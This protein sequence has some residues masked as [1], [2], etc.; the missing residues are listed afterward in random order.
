MVRR[1]KKKPSTLSLFDGASLAVIED[2]DLVRE[3]ESAY[4]EY[5]MSVIVSRALP[6]IRDG[7]KPVQRRILWGMRTSG[8]RADGPHRKC[9]K[10]VGEVMGSFHPHGDQAIYD[11][12]VRMAQNFSYYVPLVDG[13]GN[14][15][16]PGFPPA[17]MRY[18]ECRMSPTAARM[19]AGIDEDTVDFVPN[20]DGATTEPSVLPA[21]FPNLLVNG[22]E[23]IAVG[24]TTKIPT[25]NP[26]EVINGALLVLDRPDATPRQ[27]ARKIKGPDFASG[28]DILDTSG[29]IAAAYSTG[30]GRF[31]TRASVEV[32]D[33]KRGAT[34]LLFRNLPP[35][36]AVPRIADTIVDQIKKNRLASVSNVIDASDKTGVELQVVIKKGHS[37][38]AAIADLFKYTPLEQVFAVTMRALVDGVPV[39]CSLAT[40]LRAFCDHR[41]DVVL[42]R[43]IHRREKAKARRHI[44]RALIK[45]LDRIDEVIAAIKASTDVKA[46]KR[47]LCELLDIDEIQSQ[48]IVEMQL[49]RLTSLETQA[50]RDELVELELL[51]EQLTLIIDD[52]D[53]RRGVVRDELTE[54]RAEYRHEKRRSRIVTATDEV[55]EAL[56]DVGHDEDVMAVQLQI[57]RG[58][59]IEV[60][61]PDSRRKTWR[62]GDALQAPILDET[63]PVTSRVV[64]VTDDGRAWTVSL[65]DVARGRRVPLADVSEA[66]RGSNIVTSFVVADDD[67]RLLVVA[68]SDARTKKMPIGE[69][70]ASRRDGLGIVKLDDEAR[71]VSVCLVTDEDQIVYSSTGGAATRVAVADIPR[72]G[73]SAAGARAMKIGGD[74]AIAGALTV[75]PDRMVVVATSGGWLKGVSPDDIP[76]VGRAG[77]G[78]MI[79]KTTGDRGPVI[80][81]ITAARRQPV[82]VVDDANK[83]VEMTLSP[84]SRAGPGKHVSETIRSVFAPLALRK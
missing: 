47:A 56:D 82:Y 26:V 15:G 68:T 19:L 3:M 33:H 36:V 14:F 51:I 65:L 77:K 35:S 31:T 37:A 45:A 7:L 23:G 73:R 5:S 79:M 58:G 78:V 53:V 17:A 6:D 83:V 34:K 41:M 20:Y 52:E 48:A 59:W 84:S 81:A 49:R 13:Q 76:Q 18:T 9:A 1:S 74:E 4:L 10:I 80:G 63:V 27:L 22:A 43:S 25:H 64:C 72:Q 30:E 32:E 46:A 40:I 16:S 8:V 42:R 21:L 62:M 69:V 70:V 24:M 71:L 67:E 38:S 57:L 2:R 28:C 55:E 61:P 66:R 50:L 39:V 54:L 44:V 29:G 75:D 60:T 12:L 11:A